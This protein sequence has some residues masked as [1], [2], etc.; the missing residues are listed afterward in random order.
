MDTNIK[1]KKCLL[2]FFSAF[3]VI[4][5]FMYSNRGLVEAKSSKVL[6]IHHSTGANLINEGNL[7]KQ[8]YKLNPEIEIWDHGYNLIPKL[9]SFLVKILASTKLFYNTGL[10]DNNGQLT[11]TDYN[12]VLSN[13]S[14]KEYADIFSR[15]PQ[16]KTLSAV[17]QYDVVLFKNCFPTTEIKSDAQLAEYK[18]YYTQIKENLSKYQNKKF[19][20]LTSPPLRR[21]LTKPEY[22]ARAENLNN[23]LVS[24]EFTQNSGNIFVFDFFGLLADEAGYLKKEYSS[25]IP[26]DSHPNEKANHEIAPALAKFLVK[27]I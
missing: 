23:W 19:I 6:F 25:I 26:I 22:A 16:D 9:P 3:L 10:S 1:I 21:E 20:I 8:I 18:N 17:L 15:S 5:Y 12:I 24:V 27:I 13:N 11:G 2:K 4:V 14:P 7:R